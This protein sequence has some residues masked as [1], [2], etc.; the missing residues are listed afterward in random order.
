MIHLH[1]SSLRVSKPLILIASLSLL[2][3]SAC[4]GGSNYKTAEA[5][6]S[7]A[8]LFSIPKEQMGHVQVVTVEPT[9]FPRVLRLTGNVAFNGFLTTPV[10]TQVSGPVSR[11]VVS[12]GQ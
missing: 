4:S 7:K 3:L 8:G 2:A 10:I 11:L 6:N 5:D 9:V 1:S 12:P